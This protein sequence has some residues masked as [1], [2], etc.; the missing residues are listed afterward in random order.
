MCG[1]SNT[2]VYFIGLMRHFL[3]WKV[4]SYIVFIPIILK[5]IYHTFVKKYQKVFAAYFT[6]TIFVAVETSVS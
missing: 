3:D 2:E 1:W 6:F 5:K 4:W